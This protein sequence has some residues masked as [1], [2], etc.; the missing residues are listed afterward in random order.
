M[1]K[2]FKQIS[3]SM[4]ALV[5]TSTVSIAQSFEGTIEFKK[6]T[7]FDTT[8]YV[9]YVKGDQVRID[10]IGSSSGKVE[11]T[12][13]I[14]L[15]SGKMTTLSH[16]RKL[17][18]DKEATPAAK[19]KGAPIVSKT[20]NTKTIQ[21]YKCTEYLV[22]NEEE[23]TEINY[24]LAAGKFDFFNSLLNILNR[25][26]KFSVYY[27]QIQGTEGMFPFLAVQSS[28]GKEKGRME[29][30]KIEKKTLVASTF[31]IPAGY[32]EFKKE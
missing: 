14:N 26:D 12:F 31:E 4:L 30:T 9:Y 22:K 21:G 32:K 28:E 6:Q 15:K 2:L 1:K 16:D 3:I 7:T 8:D 29:A 10:E 27:Q 19:T 20:K 18:M 13:L 5:A 23:G 25:K 17:F 24:W 11:G